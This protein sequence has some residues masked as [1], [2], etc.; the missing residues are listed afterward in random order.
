MGVDDRAMDEDAQG[1]PDHH[2]NRPP[3]RPNKSSVDRPDKRP[4]HPKSI[5]EWWGRPTHREWMDSIDANIKAKEKN[6]VRVA[7]VERW[8]R[9]FGLAWMDHENL[10][11]YA[12]EAGIQPEVLRDALHTDDGTRIGVTMEARLQASGEAQQ[13][14]MGKSMPGLLAAVEKGSAGGMTEATA[15][16]LIDIFSK[17]RTPTKAAPA[18]LMI[19]PPMFT[20]TVAELIAEITA[21]GDEAR[22]LA[23]FDPG[24]S[25]WM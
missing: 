22:A 5:D 25:K 20:G 19:P 8:C 1:A 24:R 9:A 4:G 18:Q 14:L 16:K 10:D 12:F 17:G 21:A 6:K 11:S 13:V 2:A 15:L 7:I 23:A 3:D